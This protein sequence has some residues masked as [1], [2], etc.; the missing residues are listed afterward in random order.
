MVQ[1]V[2]EGCDFDFGLRLEN[3]L[4]QPSSKKVPLKSGKDKAA[5]GE[6]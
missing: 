1:K 6:G 4:C 3:S 2:P 5:K